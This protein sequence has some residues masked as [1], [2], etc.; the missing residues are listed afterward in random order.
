MANTICGKMISDSNLISVP[1]LSYDYDTK[2]E[3]FPHPI[4]DGEVVC[5]TEE[6]GA[7]DQ[8]DRSSIEGHSGLD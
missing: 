4:P 6:L 3:D 8:S 7:T 2:V 5:A 1:G